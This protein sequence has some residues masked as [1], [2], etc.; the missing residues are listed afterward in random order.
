MLDEFLKKL[1]CGEIEMTARI[2]VD[3]EVQRP[4]ECVVSFAK[5]TGHGQIAMRYADFQDDLYF[6]LQGTDL[7]F[8]RVF[9]NTSSRSQKLNELVVE[10]AGIS[11]GEHLFAQP[12]TQRTGS[13]IRGDFLRTAT[14]RGLF[15]PQ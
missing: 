13:G 5:E 3:G 9:R 4:E 6:T 12:E 2:T 1:Q 15:L 11:F 10:F 14:A 7:T 8:R